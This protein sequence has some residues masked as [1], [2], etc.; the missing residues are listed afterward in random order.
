MTMNRAKR[1]A[2]RIAA[3]RSKTRLYVAVRFDDAVW[4]IEEGARIVRRIEPEREREIARFLLQ[5]RLLV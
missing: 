2:K 4:Q 3:A 1:I 5:D